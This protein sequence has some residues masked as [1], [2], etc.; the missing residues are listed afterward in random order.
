MPVIRA[1]FSKD[2]NT[3]TSFSSFSLGWVHV[4]AR[5]LA[6]PLVFN[7]HAVAINRTT[8]KLIVTSRRWCYGI[9]VM[10][11]P[12]LLPEPENLI[13]IATDT[14]RAAEKMVEAC[15]AC[16]PAGAELLFDSILDQITGSD[17]AMTD[18]L[19]EV[20]AKCPNCRRQVFEGT[21]VEPR[22]HAK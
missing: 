4:M 7:V 2:R 17:A 18:Y 3:R 1:S 16:N 9:A 8:E 11:W 6:K 19:L 5:T 14:I 13:V 15:E 12:E 21:L 10:D 22:I 20:P